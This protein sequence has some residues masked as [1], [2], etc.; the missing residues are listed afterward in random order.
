MNS[1]PPEFNI[2]LATEKLKSQRIPAE[3]LDFGF[4]SY[5]KSRVRLNEVVSESKFSVIDVGPGFNPPNLSI[6]Q[7]SG[8]LWIGADLALKSEPN[9]TIARGDRRVEQGA[10]RVLIPGEVEVLPAFKADLI[11]MIAPNPKNIVDDDLLGQ[12]VKFLGVGTK[13]YLKLDNRTSEAKSFGAEAREVVK[14]FLKENGFV[15][16]ELDGLGDR[17]IDTSSSKDAI[18]GAVF[19]AKKVR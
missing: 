7:K 9:Q 1:S 15:P 2:D 12:V 11:M 10:K 3:V 18:G 6:D 4:Q 16:D 14:K 5:D 13:F 19:K 8:D 17:I